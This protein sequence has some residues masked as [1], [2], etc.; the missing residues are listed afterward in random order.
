MPQ[1]HPVE[2]QPRAFVRQAGGKRLVSTVRQHEVVTDR[3]L[4]DGGSDTGC[5]SGELLLVAIGSCTTGSIRTYLQS[6]GLPSSELAVAVGFEPSE[7][8]DRDRIAIEV[9]LPEEVIRERR[10]AIE[11]AAAGG[12]V[13]GRIRLGSEVALRFRAAEQS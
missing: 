4:A 13:V 3:K 11:Q 6:Q 10:P 7:A 12:A 9:S 2:E 8:G 5:T 1:E